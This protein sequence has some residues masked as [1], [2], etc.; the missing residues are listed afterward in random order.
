MAH[1]TYKQYKAFRIPNGKWIMVNAITRKPLEFP[2]ADS[3]QEALAFFR[4]MYNGNLS[5]N[6]RKEH[7]L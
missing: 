3:K 1:I 5:S 6:F 2:P 7:N 4:R